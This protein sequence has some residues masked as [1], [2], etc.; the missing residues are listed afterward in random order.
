MKQRKD[1]IPNNDPKGI[2]IGRVTFNND[3]KKLGRIKVYVEGINDPLLSQKENHKN[4]PWAW[5]M[6]PAS[7]GHDLNDGTYSIPKEGTIV[8]VYFYQHSLNHPVYMGS[9]AGGSGDRDEDTDWHNLARGT[10]PQLE[11]FGFELDPSIEFKPVYPNNSVTGFNGCTI[12]HDATEGEERIQMTHKNKSY[13]KISKSGV[14]IKSTGD[15]Q[16]TVVNNHIEYAGGAKNAY[17]DKDN[18]EVTGQ[19]KL[20]SVGEDLTELVG[21]NSS[22]NIDG[23]KTTSAPTIIQNGAFTQNGNTV[24]NG[25]LTVSQLITANGDIIWPGGIAGSNHKHSGV[26]TGSG[27][28]GPPVP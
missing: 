24:I 1:N 19:D 16:N 17:V 18:S 22:E 15:Y 12:E 20:V 10:D 26:D 23:T 28:S 3:P 8:W 11:Q 25:T 9:F 4:L 14:H 27:T 21:G 7:Y 13:L 2:Y 6:T 5:Q